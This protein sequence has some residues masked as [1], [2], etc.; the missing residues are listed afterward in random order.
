MD[1]P[2]EHDPDVAGMLPRVHRLYALAS[3]LGA[4][5]G[6]VELAPVDDSPEG[7]WRLASLVP[8][9][10]FDRQRL[11]ETRDVATRSTFLGEL[12]DDANEELRLRLAGG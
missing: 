2:A 5:I 9:G 11:L 4:D 12:I 7:L 1:E 8:L 10:E 3:E 6:A